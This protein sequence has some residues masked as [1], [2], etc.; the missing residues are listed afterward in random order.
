MGA[1][2]RNRQTLPMVKASSSQLTSRP[3]RL[4]PAGKRCGRSPRGLPVAPSAPR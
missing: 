3:R 2:A 1:P 4:V